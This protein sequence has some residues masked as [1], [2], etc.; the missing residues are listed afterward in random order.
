MTHYADRRPR[1]LAGGEGDAE[2]VDVAFE[3]VDAVVGVDDALGED[4]LVSLSEAA[5]PAMAAAAWACK[6]RCLT[7]RAFAGGTVHASGLLFRGI[8]GGPLWVFAMGIAPVN[9]VRREG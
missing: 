1:A 6:T 2:F 5:A 9:G 4:E 7:A 8:C 3:H